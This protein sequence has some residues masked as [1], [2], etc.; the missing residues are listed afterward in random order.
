MTDV[1]DLDVITDETPA[2]AAA[3][4]RC[5]AHGPGTEISDGG[6]DIGGDPRIMAHTE[7][8]ALGHEPMSPMA[9][10]RKRCL[11]CCAGNPH[12]VRLCAAVKC[13]SWPFRMGSSP[14][15]TISEGRREAGR[16]LAAR[17]HGIE[18]TPK[19][20]LGSDAN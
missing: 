10:L 8:Q 3:P 6:H 2:T 18:T 13:P 15:R 20:D 7:L 19:S 1:S 17:R 14:W 5:C 11:D 9:A 16:R 12:E 4:C